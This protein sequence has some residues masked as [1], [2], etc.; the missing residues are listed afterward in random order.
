MVKKTA[1][2]E[3][4]FESGL[5]VSLFPNVLERLRGTPARLEERVRGVPASILTARSGESWGA[6]KAI[7]VVAVCWSL[8]QIVTGYFPLLAMYQRIIHVAFAFSL[9]FCS[10][11]SET[12][13]KGRL[14][15]SP[16]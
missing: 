4:R 12:R 6:G 5:P 13:R 11:V 16:S 3:R 14:I 10:R 2:L 9:I 1:W 8:F 7:T 15:A